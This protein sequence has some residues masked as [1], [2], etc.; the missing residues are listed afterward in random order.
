[1]R[2]LGNKQR[3]LEK[4]DEFIEE[5]GIDGK[6][7][8]DLFSGSA[9]VCD[10]FKDKYRIIANDLLYSSYVLTRA[11]VKNAAVP[12][13]EKFSAATG[14]NF[15]DYFNQKEYPFEDG[16]FIWKNYSPAGVRLYFT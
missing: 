6:V 7:F 9:S 13:Y 11:K 10:H 16:H 12:R 3:M 14:K 15:F 2:Y 1:M 5:N 8:C 4:I